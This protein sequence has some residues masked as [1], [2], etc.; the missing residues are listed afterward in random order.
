MLGLAIELFP[1]LKERCIKALDKAGEITWDN[2]L[3]LKGNNMCHGITGNACLMHS[4]FRTF[5]KLSK[6]AIDKEIRR[7]YCGTAL[8]WR[9]RAYIFAQ[10][11]FDA[12]V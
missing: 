5:S 12:S 2:G 1:K 4:L 6:S 7:H 3:L 11:L 8:K 10:A 9:N